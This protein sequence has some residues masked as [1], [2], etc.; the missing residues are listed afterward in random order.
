MTNRRSFIGSVVGTAVLLPLNSSG[1]GEPVRGD[2]LSLDT[3]LEFVRAGHNNLPRV[4][5]LLA[6]E[7]KLVIAAWDWGK[8]DWET[9]LGGAGH[10]GNRENARYLLAQGARF[11]LY[12][13]AMLGQRDVILAALSNTPSSAMARGPHGYSLLYHVAI[14]GD[15]EMAK[16]IRR[17]LPEQSKDYNQS[18]AAAVRE[19]HLPMTK[20]LFDQAPLNANQ[21]DALGHSM[22]SLATEKGF[23]EIADE[24][25]RHGVKN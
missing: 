24:L 14:S 22:L 23:T 15:L 10:V 16:A 3:V 7:P 8:G 2:R 18:L 6:Q 13:A 9:A 17:L 11:D 1:Q 25:R 21:K 12:A 4:R 5:E 20:W 19:G